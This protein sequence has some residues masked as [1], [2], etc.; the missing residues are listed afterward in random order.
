MLTHVYLTKK[1]LLIM[2]ITVNTKAYEADRIGPD[3][4]GYVGPAHTFSVPDTLVL[5]R[6]APKPTATFAG[7]AR[8]SAKFS[9]LVTLADGSTATAIVESTTSLPV[10]MS[11]SDIDAIRDDM[12][13]FL[14]LQA[15][16]DLFYKSDINA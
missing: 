4:V 9:R 7:V 1:E 11:E 6:I 14:L 15:A 2:T 16:D 13:D 12:G 8:Q 3:S 10:G 5:K